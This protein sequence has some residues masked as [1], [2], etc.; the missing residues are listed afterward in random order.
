MTLS[1][2]ARQIIAEVNKEYGDGTVVIASDI[3]IPERITTGSLALDAAYGG[4]WAV[5]Q[6]HELIGEP[7]AGKTAV[8]LEAVAANQEL[9]PEFLTVWIAAEWFDRSYAEMC[10]VDVDRVIVVN[11]NIM[12]RAFGIV[13]KWLASKACDFIVIDSLPAMTPGDEAEA[14]MEDALVALGA[15]LT[16]KFFRKQG[17]SGKRALSGDER[18]CTCILIN[19]WRDK[20]GIQWGDPRTTPGGKMKDFTCVTRTEVRRDEW[21]EVGPKGNKVRIGQTIKARTIKN[22]TFPPQK[23]AT[24][25]FYFEDSAGRPAAGSYDTFKE[26][27][28]LGV[29]YDVITQKGSWY[30]YHGIRSQGLAGMLEGVASDMDVAEVLRKEVLAV[31][32]GKPYLAVREV[33][34]IETPDVP[35]KRTA[36]RTKRLDPTDVDAVVGALRDQFRK[37]APKRSPAKK[38]AGRGRR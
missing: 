33:P 23:V 3:G 9:D 25:D 10:G 15:R 35:V 20:I 36:T 19:Q 26:I 4:G 7:S 16:N 12:E 31:A 1:V 14:A 30:E 18:P 11:E 32:T 29:V 38:A 24:F 28:G 2:E 34:E 5:N 13:L 22:K 37:D 27:V 17:S 21:L 6:W 8:C